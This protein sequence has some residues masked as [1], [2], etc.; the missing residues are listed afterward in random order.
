VKNGGGKS[1]EFDRPKTAEKH[2]NL[3]SERRPDGLPVGQP[4]GPGRSGNPAGRPK[5][6]KALLDAVISDEELIA[7]AARIARGESRKDARG[8]GSRRPRDTD[9]LEAIRWIGDRKWGRT[10]MANGEPEGPQVVVIRLKPDPNSP[11]GYQDY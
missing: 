3:A 5:S 7:L 4:F 10:P 2:G 1:G 9:Q 11:T 6:L 8:R